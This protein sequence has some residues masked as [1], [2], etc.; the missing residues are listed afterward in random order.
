MLVFLKFILTRS[1][2]F[3]LVCTG[4]VWQFLDYQKLVRNAIPQTMSRLTPPIDYFAEFVDKD[5]RYDPYKLMNCIN[6]HQAVTQFF[7]FQ[8]AEGFGMLGFCYDRLGNRHLAKDSYQKAISFNPDYFWP[9]YD[10]G[11]INYNEK[12]YAGAVDYFEKAIGLN[13]L[14]TVLL[15]SR[16]KVYNDVRLSKVGGTY[17]F[18]EGIKEGRKEAYIL[19]MNSLYKNGSYPELWAISVDGIRQG[20]DTQGVF[21]YYAGLAAFNQKSYEKAVEFMQIALQ[22]DPHNSDALLYLGMCL[23][24]AGQ[25]QMAQVLLEKAAL[26]HKQEGS[27]IDNYLKARV[28]FF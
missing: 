7:D 28:R 9:Y 2:V 13:P 1:I 14:K 16:S 11:V 17:D 12:Q 22:N 24:I 6:Y 19:L 15:L 27:F 21:Y 20:L 3:Y 10:L 23:K 5:S 26:L 25:E 8:K 4:L 18:I